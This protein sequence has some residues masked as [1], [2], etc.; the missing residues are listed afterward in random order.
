[1]DWS[2]PCPITGEVDRSTVYRA[3]CCD[4]FIRPVQSS[5]SAWVVVASFTEVT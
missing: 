3:S 5:G 4:S 1:V 2:A